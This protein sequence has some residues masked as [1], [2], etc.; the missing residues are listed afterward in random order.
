MNLFGL[1][2]LPGVQRAIELCR[3]PQNFD[4]PQS[5][6]TGTELAEL[7]IR[8]FSIAQWDTIWESAEM[9]NERERLERE[10][11]EAQFNATRLPWTEAE[12]FWKAIGWDISDGHGGELICAHYFTRQIIVVTGDLV[13]GAKFTPDGTGRW[14][15][16]DMTASE[17]LGE[18]LRR[19]AE[20]FMIGRSG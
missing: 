19:E 17:S 12:T 4:Y 16:D 7:S 8:L 10:E 9:E 5:S 2:D 6:Y 13:D 11:Y 20:R 14:E 1:R 18:R 3:N 15:P